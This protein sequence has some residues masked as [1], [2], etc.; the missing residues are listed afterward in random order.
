MPGVGDRI[1]IACFVECDPLEV[2]NEQ[3]AGLA[4]ALETGSGGRTLL[5]APF[6]PVVPGVDPDLTRL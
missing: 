2:W 6:V 3:F 4:T 5:V 1:L